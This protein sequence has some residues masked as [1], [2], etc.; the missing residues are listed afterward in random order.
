MLSKRNGTRTDGAHIS[1]R[2]AAATCCKACSSVANA[3]MR[4]VDV[5]MTHAMRMS[6]A[7]A[8]TRNLYAIFP[9]QYLVG[10][11]PGGLYW[12]PVFNILEGLMGAALVR[13]P[14][15]QAPQIVGH[16]RQRPAFLLVLL[17]EARDHRVIASKSQ[18]EI[19]QT[20]R[21]TV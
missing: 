20:I 15:R 21:E 9:F 12:K 1:L 18:G 11:I 19:Y 6:T 17:E 10:K 14:S 4:I 7:Q 8:G 3:G 16:G 2:K 13:Y 5:P